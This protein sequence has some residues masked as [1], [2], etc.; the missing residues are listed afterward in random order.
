M[1]TWILNGVEGIA[2]CRCH[3]SDF[4][5]Q[6][7]LRQ[8]ANARDTGLLASALSPS[9]AV[10]MYGK[11]KRMATSATH[12]RQRR[13]NV[14]AD[15][16]ISQSNVTLSGPAV[17]QDKARRIQ[18]SQARQQA[19]SESEQSLLQDIA[20]G[21]APRDVDD[22]QDTQM[23]YEG[24]ING[25]EQLMISNAGGELEA[26]RT[27]G[28]I[29]QEQAVYQL[30]GGFYKFKRRRVDHRTRRDRNER[31]NRAFQAMA[32]TLADA[33]MQW[34][35]AQTHEHAPVEPELGERS[36]PIRVIDLFKTRDITCIYPIIDGSPAPSIIRHGAMPTAPKS[37]SVAISIQ[38]LEMYRCAHFRC[39]QF[40]IQ[41]FVKTILDVQITPY[42]KHLCRQ[43]SIAYDLYLMIRSTVDSRVKHALGRDGPNWELLHNCPACFNELEEDQPM[44]YSVLWSTDGNDSLKRLD[45]RERS[46]EQG[47]LGASIE[48][49]DTRRADDYDNGCRERWKNMKNEHTAKAWG[50]F[51]ETGIFAGFCRHGFTL[52]LADMY[53]TG[54][55]VKYFLSAAEKLLRIGPR[56]QLMCIDVGCRHK[57]TLGYSDLAPLAKERGLVIGVDK[58]H[59]HAHNRLCQV[60]NL[61]TYLEGAGLE[62]FGACERN[63]SKSNPLAPSTRYMGEYRRKQAIAEHYKNMDH[64]ENYM[65]MTTFLLN[66][67]KQ[68]LKILREAPV[69][70]EIAKM[71]LGLSHEDNDTIF[72]RCLQE[73]TE[74]L[75]NL[76]KEPPMETLQMELHQRLINL[77]KSEKELS[78]IQA[79]VF[80][81]EDPGSSRH[82]DNTNAIETRRR[83]A[84]ENCE[85]ARSLVQALETQLGIV[86]R[87]AVGS[88]E[89]KDAERK[90]AMRQYQ[91][92]LDHLEGL[93]VGRIFELNDMNRSQMGYK[94]R[95]HIGQALHA[96]S[97]AIRTALTRYNDA[98]QNVTPP[99][100]TLD[101]NEVIEWAFLSD[102]DLLR[103]ARQDVRERPWA[104]PIGRR[105]VNEYF[106]M[107]RARE[108][109]TRCN[110]EVRRIATHLRDE[111]VF[112]HHQEEM[113][114]SVN[115]LLAHQI[116]K[117]RQVRGRFNAHHRRQLQAIARLDGF[118]GSIEPGQ[119]LDIGPGAAASIGLGAAIPV[120]E[121]LEPVPNRSQEEEEL[122]IEQ[123]DDEEA[124]QE[125][126]DM[127]DIL[128]VAMDK[129]VIAAHTSG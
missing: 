124:A 93:V 81:M 99:R 66:N 43:F 15:G 121:D 65:N 90:V 36:I 59:C 125:A 73:E 28:D 129:V 88:P 105:A 21:R 30:G 10:K 122:E 94:E 1:E 116:A 118:S 92:A 25:E 20:I 111:A 44:K 74:Y 60:Y 103:D 41:A 83:H 89:F 91:R 37:P 11:R 22:E 55:Q 82:R 76:P 75:E 101:F 5:D 70:L 71:E 119:S 8:V 102:F 95:Q 52:T 123:D 2:D 69:N 104:T 38:A 64:M 42:Q 18:Q 9:I 50:C 51:A 63:F 17:V 58:F 100:Q 67:Y 48:S 128:A 79:V 54:E 14:E 62:D 16:S 39:P 96:R 7:D 32:E 53:R 33:F 109:L 24:V 86:E 45:R 6:D 112:L 80:H 110:N 46:T 49:I 68:A 114:R 120:C 13:T 126:D 19:M 78:S 31:R 77:W 117:Y 108:E 106:H 23:N 12:Y 57:I 107:L 113:H 35:Y 61:P 87:W 4:V 3:A 26:L 84:I 115:P 98:A 72:P 97:G 85:K 27:S 127:L 56:N 40:S 34:D 47:T 29:G